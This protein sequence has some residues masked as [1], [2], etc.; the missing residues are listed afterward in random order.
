M[1]RKN[2]TPTPHNEK[3]EIENEN[4]KKIFFEKQTREYNPPKVPKPK[5]PKILPSH[6]LIL[7]NYKDQGFR[8]LGKAVRK[9]GVYSE[10]VA[11]RVNAITNTKSWKLLMDEFLPEEHLARRHS[12]LL[13][14]RAMRTVK[15][16][17]GTE[18]EIDAGPETAAVTKGLEMAY[19]LRGSFSK[20]DTPAPS[21]VMYNL[22][23][24]PEV[25]EQMRVFED[26]LK[27]SLF[28][29]I[30]KRNISDAE[31]EEQNEVNRAAGEGT[32]DSEGGAGRD[33]DTATEGEQT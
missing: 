4:R 22:F 8:H 25:R 16:A 7:E 29:E 26:G 13:D 14:K 18:E 24:K 10:T 21:T 17:D 6:R 9:T 15:F 2:N 30:N 5:G 27:Q 19:R 23:Y 20:E 1:K 32:G 28:N 31:I 33:A 3:R 11:R 12:E